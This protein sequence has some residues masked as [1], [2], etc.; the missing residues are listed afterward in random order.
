MSSKGM[1]A[2]DRIHAQYWSRDPAAP[3]SVGL[4]DAAAFDVVP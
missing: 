1:Q 3:F 4:T 2:G